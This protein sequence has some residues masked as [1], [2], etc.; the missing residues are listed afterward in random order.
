MKNLAWGVTGGVSLLLAMACSGKNLH[1][2][3]D[4]DEGSQAG[5]G[6][7]G[8]VGG[9]GGTMIGYGD[10]TPVS[11]DCGGA[12]AYAGTGSD[13][14]CNGTAGVGTAGTNTAGNYGMGGGF[15]ECFTLPNSS[16]AVESPPAPAPQNA[17]FIDSHNVAADTVRNSADQQLFTNVGR[18]YILE[19]YAN[20]P[21]STAATDTA[22]L[23]PAQLSQVSANLGQ[24]Y[25]ARPNCAGKSVAGHKLTVE[26]WWKLGAT[27]AYPTHGVALG[28][29]SDN[30]TAVWFEDSVKTYTVGDAETARLMNT[31]NR[32]KVEHSFA[33]DD[34]TDASKVTLGVWLLPE[35]ELATTLY[36]GPIKWD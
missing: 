36:I 3:G 10:D 29:V 18:G 16:Y 5:S 14:V 32:F 11:S 7:R 13:Y 2:V 4:V 23:L 30:D 17:V 8:N 25:I 12:A 33:E 20:F 19:A 22:L 15:A 24:F 34:D 9:I 31:L 26:F 27:A 35:A 21:A 28:A 6:G 1:D